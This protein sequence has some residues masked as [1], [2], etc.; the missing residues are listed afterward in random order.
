MASLYAQIGTQNLP[1]YELGVL[2]TQSQ[3]SIPTV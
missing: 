1:E 3:R 2:S